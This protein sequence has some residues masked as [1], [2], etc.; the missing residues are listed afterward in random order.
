MLPPQRAALVVV[1]MLGFSVADVAEVLGISLG[2]VKSRCA[3]ARLLPHVAHLRGN[4]AATE[5][6]HRREETHEGHMTHL[7]AEVLAEFRAGII[8]GR[9]GAMLAAHLADCDRC[10]ELGDRL[11]EVSAMLA[12]APTP[13]IPGAVAS[14]LDTALAAEVAK[15]DDTKRARGDSPHDRRE[16]GRLTRR[17]GFR[18]VAV[19]VL[20]PAAAMVVL[21]A[22]G[23]GLSP[24]GGGAVSNS[25]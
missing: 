11:A 16:A 6:V 18:L 14:R 12:A 8:T 3:R 9:R 25:G 4:R 7:D 15:K 5:S 17:R 22:G 24:I 10:A 23:Y 21:A 19:R 1:D 2:T 20:A 13:A